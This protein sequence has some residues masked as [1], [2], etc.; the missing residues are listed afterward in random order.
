MARDLYI[1]LS[2]TETGMGKLIRAVTHFRY[3]HVSLSVDPT[4]RKWHSFARLNKNAALVGGYVEENPE[5]YAT[6]GKQMPVQIF[7]IPLSEKAEAVLRIAYKN[8]EKLTYNS[9]SAVT[10]LFHKDFKVPGA[11][12]CLSFANAVMDTDFQRISDLQAYLQNHLFYEGDFFAL[13]SSQN[14]TVGSYYDEKGK[15]TVCKETVHHFTDLTHRAVHKRNF[16]DP[17]AEIGSRNDV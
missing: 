7:K 1:M 6:T 9:F 15:M 13:V 16:T 2:S 14:T 4:L 17:I 10:S 12:T 8:R 5:R 3:N 11:Y